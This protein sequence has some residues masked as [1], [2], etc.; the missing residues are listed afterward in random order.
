MDWIIENKEWISAIGIAIMGGIISF[1]KIIKSK[2]AMK[3]K[4]KSGSHSK[5]IQVGGDY[6][7]GK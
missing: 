5:N 7:A 6:H 2:K 1:L 3:M 4:Q